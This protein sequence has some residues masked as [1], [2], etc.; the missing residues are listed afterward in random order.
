MVSIYFL[1]TALYAIIGGPSVGKT[2]IIESL[3]EEGEATVREVATDLIEEKMKKGIKEPWNDHD[4]QYN[5][6]LTHLKREEEALKSY[7]MKDRIF[8]DRGIL[9][10]YIYLDLRDKLKTDEF[11][12]VSE[13]I[14]SVNAGNR[15]EAVF[16]VEPHSGSAFNPLITEVR[17]EDLDESQKICNLTLKVYKKHYDLVHVPS[18]MTPKERAQFIMNYVKNL[19]S[20]KSMLV[21]IQ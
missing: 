18:Q 20:K 12:K 5:I 2:S 7:N 11:K 10:S 21:S 8:V 3:K 4:F 1:A 15:Y 6:T 14:E 19:E 17:H 13:V 16:Y 9:D